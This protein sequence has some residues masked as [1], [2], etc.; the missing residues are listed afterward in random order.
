[1]SAAG[2]YRVEAPFAV[3]VSGSNKL[4]E[5][6][7][8]LVAF[9]DPASSASYAVYVPNGTYADPCASGAS[10]QPAPTTVDG[11]VEAFGSTQ[12]FRLDSSVDVTLDGHAGKAIVLRNTQAADAACPFG[13]WIPIF[14]YAGGPAEGAATNRGATEYLWLIDVAGTPVVVATS[15]NARSFDQLDPLI[16]SIDFDD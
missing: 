2:T 14:S 7:E 9:N 4:D 8:A 10:P 3:T 11:L 6:G 16:Q 15:T 12:G 13:P 5:L 1:M